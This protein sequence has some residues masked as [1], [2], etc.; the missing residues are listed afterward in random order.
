LPEADDEAWMGR[1]RG[2]SWLLS[3]VCGS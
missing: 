2:V 3:V 1:K